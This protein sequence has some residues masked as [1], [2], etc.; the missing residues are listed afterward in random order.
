MAK[1]DRPK[2]KPA[3]KLTP[4]QERFC[5]Y[6]VNQRADERVSAA[7]AYRRAYPNY[8][9]R[10][11]AQL[12]LRL[13][14]QH[15][16]VMQRIAQLRDRAAKRLEVSAERVLRELASIAFS[17]I[18]RLV[19]WDSAGEQTLV[20]S[21]EL[22]EE[23]KAA[24]KDI[25]TDKSRTRVRLHDKVAALEKLAKHLGLFTE[26]VDITSGGQSFATLS[27]EQRVER[28]TQ[29]LNTARTRLAGRDA[30]SS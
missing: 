25:A 20:A 27:D 23:D 15:P 16:I 29:L 26:K 3:S 18:S 21:D 9:G 13:L 11:A 19:H 10:H 22:L 5:I 28:I 12:A 4:G 17:D 30:P 8:N 24:I 7:E 2:K 6:Y 14:Q 1:Q